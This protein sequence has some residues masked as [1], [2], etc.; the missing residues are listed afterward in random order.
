MRNSFKNPLPGVP[1]VESPFFER[2]LEQAE[3]DAETR[4]IAWDLHDK[5]YAVLEFPEPDFDANAELLIKE[6]TPHYDWAG[7]E[8]GARQDLRIQDAWQFN[9][10]VRAIAAN[11]RVLEILSTIYGRRAFP[12]QTLNFAVGSQQHYHTDS[13]HFSSV[14]ERFMCG[15]WLALEDIDLSQG[16]LIYYPGSHRLP[17]YV[18]EH[19][20]HVAA[21]FP[22][23]G[24]HVYHDAWHALV[25]HYGFQPERLVVKRGTALIWSSNLLHGGDHHQDRSRTRWSQVTHYFFENCAYYTPMYSDPVMGSMLLRELVDIST[26]ERVKNKYGMYDVP[27][28]HIEAV[29]PERNQ[30]P[31]FDPAAYLAANPD[32][33]AAGVDPVLHY[34]DFGRYEGRRLR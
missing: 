7:W 3:P 11:A 22:Q 15:V 17:I 5:G 32:V 21:A 29:R 12:F 14:P 20:G 24:Q 31:G 6:L 33:A 1:L 26:G 34:L 4:R 16:P 13:V 8:S 18:N 30:L 19:V 25:E 23:T 9:P 27:E 28:R 2:L 10:R